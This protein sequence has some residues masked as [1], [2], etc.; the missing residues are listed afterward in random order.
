MDFRTK[1]VKNYC[2]GLDPTFNAEFIENYIL[3]AALG[4]ASTLCYY[5]VEEEDEDATERKSFEKI[6]NLEDRCAIIYITHLLNE[7]KRFWYDPE[8][9]FSDEDIAEI[10]DKESANSVYIFELVSPKINCY[11]HYR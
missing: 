2:L 10:G 8:R 9:P 11:Y 1:I 5:V 4:V 3:E 6:V 7:S